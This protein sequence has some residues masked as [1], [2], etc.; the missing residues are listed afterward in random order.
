MFSRESDERAV[1]L[2]ARVNEER[3]VNAA[4]RVRMQRLEASLRELLELAEVEGGQDPRL[5]KARAL[6]VDDWD[7][8]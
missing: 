4:L 2:Q 7:R 5:V 1:R 6:L 3:R 8:K